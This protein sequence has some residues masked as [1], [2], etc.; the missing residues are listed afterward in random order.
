[1]YVIDPVDKIVFGNATA[2][3]N[4]SGAVQTVCLGCTRKLLINVGGGFFPP[5]VGVTGI[6]VS[7]GSDDKSIMT[8]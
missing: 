7:V 5:L 2:L 4:G 6:L 8:I 3:W 1:M